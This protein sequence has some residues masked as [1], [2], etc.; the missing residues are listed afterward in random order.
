NGGLFNDLIVPQVTAPGRSIWAAYGQ[1][2]GGDGDF[3]YNVI[4]GTSMASPHVAGAGALLK[5]LHPSWTPA[6]IQ[7][8]LMSTAYTAIRNDDGVNPATPFAQG[9]GRVDLTQAAHAGIVLD[10]TTDEYLAADPAKGGDPKQINLASMADHQ[11]LLT[12]SWTRTV[13]STLATAETWTVGGTGANGV[14]ITANP[15]QFELAPGATQAIVITADATGAPRDQ[16]L[17]GQVQLTPG[18]SSPAA[19][20]PVAIVSS[21][22]IF[23]DSVDIHTRRDAGSQLVTGLR[24]IGITDLTVT[25]HGLVGGTKTDLSL[26]EDPTNGDPY[27]NVND[28]SVSVTLVDVPAGALRLA[29]N[30]LASEAPDVDMY[31]GT[32][33]VPS[34]DTE[35]CVSASGTALES[36]LVDYPA[37]GTWW[38]LVQNWEASANAPDV[39]TL[40]HAVVA[41]DNGNLRVEGPATVAAGTPFDV[42]VFWN[43]PAL[44]AGETWY[45]AFSLGT[46]PANPGNLGTIFVNVIREADD[47]VKT[48]SP[49]TAAPGVTVTYQIVVD[50]NVTPEDLAYTIQDTIPAGVTYVPNSATASAGTVAV[51]GNALTWTGVMPSATSVPGHYNITTNQAD[52]MC[53]PPIGDG[54]YYD[55]L[56]RTGFTTDPGITGDTINWAYNSFAGTDF[57]GAT[58]AAPPRFTDDGFVAFGSIVGEPWVN[59]NIPDPTPPNA[60]LAPYWRDMEVVYDA[61][62]NKGVTSIGFGGGV[63]WLVEFD[64]IQA[65]HDP[66]TSLDLEVMA[67]KTIDPSAGSYDAYYAFDNVHVADT[68]GTIGVENDAGDA[69]TQFAYDNF[70]PTNGLVL[71]L[72][73]VGLTPTVITYQATVNADAPAGVI[74]NQVVHNTNNPGSQPATTS[75][76]LTVSRNDVLFLSLSNSAHVP[77]LSFRDEDI[78]A[79][80]TQ[81]GVWS[82]FFDGSDVGV[83]DNDVNAFDLKDGE[84]Y[85]SFNQSKNMRGQGKFQGPDKIEDTD[86]YH[87]VPT[88]LG[89]NTAG[90][91]ELYFDGSD[92]GLTSDGEDIDALFI[93][94]DGNLIISTLG[95]FKVPGPNGTELRGKDEDLLLFTPTSLGENTSGTWQ[96]LLDGSAEGLTKSSEDISGVWLN[97]QSQIFLTTKDNFSVNGASG[98]G[99]D[100]FICSRPDANTLCSFSLALDGSTIG[101]GGK[102][103]DDFAYGSLPPLA[104]A[105]SAEAYDAADDL[106]EANDN[107]FDDVDDEEDA[108]QT[109]TLYLPFVTK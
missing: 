9:S 87:F 55:A 41:G 72:D 62:T 77:N 12:C 17:F 106:P 53:A 15:A 78:V 67:W 3:T 107:A 48:V 49:P 4:Q 69:A 6:E 98:D 50:T 85:L 16:W 102:H 32:G 52:P 91:F 7:S 66:T 94:P 36:C 34:A 88:S 61:P 10:T 60:L 63:F 101:L 104:A 90:R 57:Y 27:D 80:N 100:I 19:H 39:I 97:A 51:N 73:Y 95:S 23:S 71:C 5:A 93:T 83:S 58:R 31:V 96:L 59:Q 18:G 84:L 30:I 109:G 26:N 11:C 25:T 56:T 54:G 75:A 74:T 40:A 29:A 33:S 108:T 82:Q 68:V 14:N 65:F 38:I 89:A 105:A 64:D 43:E 21:A 37:A 8:A 1:G 99:A 24:A 22:S 103:I 70:T 42:R 20:F 86:I 46:D 13:K 45:G 76:D 79:Y 2:P 35:V 81:T 44:Q 92:V 28:G 47:V